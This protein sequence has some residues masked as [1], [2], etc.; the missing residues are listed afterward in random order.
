MIAVFQDFLMF[1]LATV[2]DTCVY[3]FSV[4][5]SL[6]LVS[7]YEGHLACK[8]YYHLSSTTYLLEAGLAGSKS[9][10]W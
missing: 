10:Q 4:Q 2:W 5:C 8:R 7:R 6:F 9:Q 1:P 3:Y